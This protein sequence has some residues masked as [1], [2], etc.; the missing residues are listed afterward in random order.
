MSL[1]LAIIFGLLH[2]VN[3]AHGAQYM[4]GAFVAWGL[5]EYLGLGY[6]WA[7]VIAPL[8]VGR[9]RPADRAD[10][11][12]PPVQPRPCLRAAADLRRRA[13]PRRRVPPASSAPRGQPY[14]NPISGRPRARRWPS[15]RGTGC[16]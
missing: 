6:W 8:V 9:A 1:G 13:H 5:L 3:F 14:P 2:V 16:G 11:A 7:L 15:S 12:A 4:L 10:D